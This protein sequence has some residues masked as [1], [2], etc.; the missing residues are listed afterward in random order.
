MKA[1][2]PGNN[3]AINHRGLGNA[4]R[5]PVVIRCTLE[6]VPLEEITTPINGDDRRR[7]I[8]IESEGDLFDEGSRAVAALG[9]KIGMMKIVELR[10]RARVELMNGF[11][12]RR[13]HDA[14]LLD[15]GLPLPVLEQ[16]VL[17]WVAEEKK[18]EEKKH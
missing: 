9:Y 11:D 1:G 10:K 12:I 2:Q 15:G 13:F 4:R 5:L 14:L 6:G 17:K 7:V 18:L 8:G 16:R 3:I